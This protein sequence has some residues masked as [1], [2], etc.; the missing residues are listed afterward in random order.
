MII[1]RSY[2]EALT[3]S[4]FFNLVLIDEVW[5]LPMT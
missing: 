4:V 3:Q 5:L 2:R 1:F